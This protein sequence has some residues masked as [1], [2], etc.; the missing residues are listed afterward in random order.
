MQK[1]INDLNIGERILT[2][3]LATDPKNE[4]ID[5]EAFARKIAES[6]DE[7][8]ADE[9]NAYHVSEHCS[10]ADYAIFC[11]GSS[12]RH[13][14][15]IADSVR[16]SS[17]KNGVVPLGMEGYQ[18]AQW[19]LIDLGFV[20]VHIFYAPVRE[21]YELERI[22]VNA[23]KMKFVASVRSAAWML[24]DEEDDYDDDDDDDFDA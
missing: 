8:K 17:K 18:Q 21:Y 11:S 2:D 6:I 10:Y 13:A 12:E 9:I 5:A 3:K 23:P 15:A 22:W 19:I 1:R 14:Q 16:T 7:K 24:D 20:I 4:P